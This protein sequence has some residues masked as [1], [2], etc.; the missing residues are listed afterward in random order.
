MSSFHDDIRVRVGLEPGAP[1][2]VDARDLKTWSYAELLGVTERCGGFFATHGASPTR[3][4]MAK[5]GAGYRWLSPR[6]V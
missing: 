2:I 6:C 3:P 4:V 5:S 1:A